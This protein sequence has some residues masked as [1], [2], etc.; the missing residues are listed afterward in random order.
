MRARFPDNDDV[1][2]PGAEGAGSCGTVCVPVG[3][4]CALAKLA[5]ARIVKS[6]LRPTFLAC[7][8]GPLSKKVPVRMEMQCAWPGHCQDCQR[9]QV[10]VAWIET[11]PALPDDSRGCR[12]TVAWS[13]TLSIS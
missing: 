8:I 2:L 13:Q 6:M 5:H 12:A 9:A 10:G 3:L 4:C 11:Y 1:S 7:G